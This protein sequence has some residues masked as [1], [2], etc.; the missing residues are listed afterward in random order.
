MTDEITDYENSI[1][2]IEQKLLSVQSSYN[3]ALKTLN[4]WVY[5]GEEAEKWNN[6]WPKARIEY[7]TDGKYKHDVRGFI[8]NKC[9]TIEKV[10]CSK[11][12]DTYDE[13]A[14]ELL[15]YVKKRLTYV[16]DFNTHKMAEHWQTPE[17]TYQSKKG[18]CEDGAILLASM[19]LV[20]GIPSYRVKL[21]CGFVKDPS[22][23]KKQ[24]GHAYVIYL[25]DDDHWYVCD[26]CYWY[27]ESVRAFKKKAHNEMTN[28]KD[29]WWTANNEYTW[30]QKNVLV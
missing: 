17:E 22:N 21:C 11:V 4:D 30:S 2:E 24:A 29:I 18:D 26:W 5:E 6:K 13:T 28:Y 8:K 9:Y 10:A 14:L 12:K 20:A 27:T 25:A 19:M 15:K 1:K 7:V 16:G 23:S 3:E